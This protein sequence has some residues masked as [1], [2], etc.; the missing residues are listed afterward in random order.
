MKIVA[1][2]SKMF[3]GRILYKKLLKEILLSW[4]HLCHSIFIFNIL[5]TFLF[6]L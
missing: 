4:F 2:Y 1:S 5:S 6:Y 3:Y